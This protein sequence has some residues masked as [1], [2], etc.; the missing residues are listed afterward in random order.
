MAL[1]LLAPGVVMT[2]DEFVAVNFRLW[3]KQRRTLFN[4]LLLGAALALLGM[5]VALDIAANKQVTNWGTA[6]VLV[7]GLLYGLLRMQLV[8][9]Q[10]RRG[11]AKN[12]GLREP[13]NFTF[14]TQMLWGQSTN[15]HFEA[16]W[17]IMRRA[18][19]VQPNWLLLYPTETA[20]YYVDLRRLQAPSTPEQLLALVRE[21]GIAVRKV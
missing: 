3:R 14:D 16:P 21:A 8:R 10:L 1:P 15:S 19:W 20:C 5:S 7:V 13:T 4:Y 11:Y 18:A 9:Y 2:A 12:T 17:S 6:S